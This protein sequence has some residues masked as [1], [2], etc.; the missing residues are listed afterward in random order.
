MK[1]K[2]LPNEIN[3]DHLSSV[4]TKK[5]DAI[6]RDIAVLKLKL[7]EIVILKNKFVHDQLYNEAAEH[8]AQEVVLREQLSYLKDELIAEDETLAMTRANFDRKY[9]LRRLIHELTPLEDT[10]FLDE[11]KE[12]TKAAIA[13]LMEQRKN[14]AKKVS[15]LEEEFPQDQILSKL[16]DQREL[17][18]VL[19]RMIERRDRKRKGL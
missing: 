8:R 9:D 2:K 16:M 7:S 1:K 6:F 10:H 13:S 15:D 17:L 18:E 19:N 14:P 11:T 3:Q 5:A 12:R 4:E